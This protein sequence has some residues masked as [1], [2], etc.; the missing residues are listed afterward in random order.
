MLTRDICLKTMTSC[1]L[2]SVS[3]QTLF[4]YG[5]QLP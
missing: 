3:L 4:Q 5:A 1:E 2:H